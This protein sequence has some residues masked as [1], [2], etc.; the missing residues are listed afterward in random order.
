MVAAIG[1][2]GDIPIERNSES[3]LPG[4]ITSSLGI[5]DSF[6]PQVYIS[7]RHLLDIA[8]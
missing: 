3:E 4:F 8:Q 5:V 6:I 1:A 7:V 2:M